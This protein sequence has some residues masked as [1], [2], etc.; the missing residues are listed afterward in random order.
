MIC[1]ASRDTARPSVRVRHDSVSGSASCCLG[2]SVGGR[3]SSRSQVR[4]PPRVPC[5]QQCLHSLSRVGQRAS[6][7]GAWVREEAGVL[8]VERK[9]T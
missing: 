9:Q 6:D 5:H 4:V 2:H 8:C 7:A 3:A 1:D